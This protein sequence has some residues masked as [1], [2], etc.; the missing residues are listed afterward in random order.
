MT[1]DNIITILLIIEALLIFITF[2]IKNR[3]AYAV[4]IAIDCIA[5]FGTT[6][7]MVFRDTQSASP[8]LS[9]LCWVAAYVIVK[10]ISKT[11]PAKKVWDYLDNKITKN[12]NL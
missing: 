12:L 11:K 4:F 6:G 5:A 10:L 9:A 2:Q 7:F 3:T 1:Y 8:V